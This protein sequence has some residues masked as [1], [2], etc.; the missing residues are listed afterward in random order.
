MGGRNR[1]R[2]VERLH[3]IKHFWDYDAS[4]ALPLLLRRPRAKEFPMFTPRAG[5][6][7]QSCSA[8]LN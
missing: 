5:T 7:S 6:C 1:D 3:V 8:F 2:I 4:F